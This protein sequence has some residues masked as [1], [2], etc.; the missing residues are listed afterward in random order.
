[1]TLKHADADVLALVTDLPRHQ[2][3]FQYKLISTDRYRVPIYTNLKVTGIRGKRRVE[4]IELTDV[5]DGSVQ[6]I[7][8]DTVVFTGDWIPD[9]E[10]AFYGGLKIDTHSKSPCVDQRL[11]TSMKGVFA[12]GNVIHAAET[13]DVA[14]LSGRYAAHS[15]CDYL[16]TGGWPTIPAMPIEIDEPIYWISPQAITPGQAAA[17]HGCFIVRVAKE[18][19]RPA[20]EVWQDNRCLWRKRYR[21]LTPNL[22]IYVPDR[23][24][25]QIDAAAGSIRFVITN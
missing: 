6:E 2:S 1:M 7:E 13:A 14:A 16:L 12:A 5:V 17:P 3:F 15:V 19:S 10:L 18:L 20:L 22:P 25:S 8:C 24:L 21:H 23:W 11:Q 9:Y 4:A